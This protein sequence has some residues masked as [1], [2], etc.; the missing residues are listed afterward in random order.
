MIPLH[1]SSPDGA[2][3]WVCDPGYYRTTPAAVSGTPTCRAC[4]SLG[5]SCALGF[6]MAPCAYASDVTCIRCPVPPPGYVYAIPGTCNTTL[7]ADGWTPSDT[8]RFECV[9]CPVGAYCTRAEGRQP[10]GP[11]CTTPE[12][13]ASSPL[14]CISAAA[15]SSSSSSSLFGF[16]VQFVFTAPVLGL[17]SAQ[18]DNTNNS[19][20]SSSSSSSTCPALDAAFLSWLAYGSYQSCDLTFLSD[21]LGLLTCTLAAAQCVAGKY[22][23]YLLFTLAVHQDELATALG[24]CLSAPDLILG[25]PLVQE[26]FFQPHAA[27]TSHVPLPTDAPRF[28]NPPRRWGQSHLETLAT[29]VVVAVMLAGMCVGLAAACALACTRSHRRRLARTLFARLWHNRHHHHHS[30]S[31]SSSSSRPRHHHHHSPARI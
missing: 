16:S 23:Q 13:G 17:P 4:T 31:S 2:S 7:C 10:C 3:S 22:L 14:Q 18:T 15:S 29:L 9:P 25:A 5:A 24:A 20:V 21:T 28:R 11:N 30:H 19:S 27:I 6:R 1:S 12:A 8:S 26:T